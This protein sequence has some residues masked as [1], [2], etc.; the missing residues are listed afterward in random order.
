M[1]PVTTRTVGYMLGSLV[2][3][4]DAKYGSTKCVRSPREVAV[5]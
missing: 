2:L 1:A 4:S 3:R 5:T